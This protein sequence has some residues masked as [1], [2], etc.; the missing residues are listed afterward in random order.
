[1]GKKKRLPVIIAF[2]AVLLIGILWVAMPVAVRLSCSLRIYCASAAAEEDAVDYVTY[3]NGRLVFANKESLQFLSKMAL[4]GELEDVTGCCLAPWP[5]PTYY[6][7]E[8]EIGGNDCLLYHHF[9]RIYIITPKGETARQH[10]A[11]LIDNAMAFYQ[12]ESGQILEIQSHMADR[13]EIYHKAGDGAQDTTVTVTDKMTVLELAAMYDALQTNATSRSMADDPFVLTFYQEDKKLW[14]W[15]IAPWE[16]DGR[17]ITASSLKHGNYMVKNG[18][19]FDRLTE[20][21][22]G[23]QA[24]ARD[25]VVLLSELISSDVSSVKVNGYGDTVELNESE[26]AEF[27]E[28]TK[29]IEYRIAGEEEKDLMAAPG[30][31]TVTITVQYSDGESEQF[32]LPYCLHEDTMYIAPAQSIAPF[33]R[34]LTGRPVWVP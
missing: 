30:A 26:L 1:M 31:A 33:L 7:D 5:I 32:T 14:T 27:F 3:D 9:G 6:I 15:W 16:E 25:G 2:A 24:E 29:G 10:F 19:D 21:S 12:D 20:L 34:Y 4:E 13:V 23:Q 17:V 8:W 22:K 18:F 28:I 11:K